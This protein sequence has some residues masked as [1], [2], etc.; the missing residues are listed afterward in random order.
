MVDQSSGCL[1]V[2]ESTKK[3]SIARNHFGMNK[4][5]NETEEDF[6]NL[7]EVIC[8]MERKAITRGFVP[9]NGGNITLPEEKDPW[10]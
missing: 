10:Q 3:Q 2:S 4:F 6:L 1:D 5:R 9:T 8:D 7:C